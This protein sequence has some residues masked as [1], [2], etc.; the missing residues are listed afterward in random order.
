VERQFQHRLPVRFTDYWKDFQQKWNWS[1][2]K[3]LTLNEMMFCKECLELAQWILRQEDINI[4]TKYEAAFRCACEGGQ[5]KIACWFHPISPI[6]SEHYLSAFRNACARGYLDVVQWLYDIY[7]L[8]IIIDIVDH[9]FR[10]AC[11]G[12]HLNIV[13]WLLTCL[14][15]VYHL[16]R[17]LNHSSRKTSLYICYE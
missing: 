17:H 14:C 6:N 10:L 15:P 9:P 11:E 4:H 12:N 16:L 7:N 5:L 1:K 8:A 3:T 2:N 13:Q